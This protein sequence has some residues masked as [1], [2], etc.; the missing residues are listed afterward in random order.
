MKVVW[1]FLSCKKKSRLELEFFFVTWF[2]FEFLK[3]M[4]VF[5]G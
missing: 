4:E 1:I 3:R 2:N 5:L